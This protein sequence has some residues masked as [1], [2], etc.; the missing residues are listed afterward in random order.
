MSC[1]NYILYDS[2]YL[3]LFFF[4]FISSSVLLGFYHYKK[5][6]SRCYFHLF[7]NICCQ[8]MIPAKPSALREYNILLPAYGEKLWVQ[9]VAFSQV[10]KGK[11]ILWSPVEVHWGFQEKHWRERNSFRGVTR[12]EEGTRHHLQPSPFTKA[13]GILLKSPLE[14]IRW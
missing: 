9:S 1:M 13:K 6:V 5:A 14:L 7:L 2:F 8:F 12:S 10:F 3:C 4:F 11:L